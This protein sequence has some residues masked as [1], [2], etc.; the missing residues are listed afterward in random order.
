MTLTKVEVGKGGHQMTQHPM[1][2]NS[3][4]KKQRR[5]RNRIVFPLG[6]L[7]RVSPLASHFLGCLIRVSPLA[8]HFSGCLNRVSPL[9]SHFS[10]CLIRV[11][12]D[13]TIFLDSIQFLGCF[14]KRIFIL[15]L[16]LLRNDVDTIGY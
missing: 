16:A 2:L 10:G 9:A 8:S 6:Y 13:T 15:S 5:R 12:K 1:T 14:R 3:I 7:I 4:F 11:P